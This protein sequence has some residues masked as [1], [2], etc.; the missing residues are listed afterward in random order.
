MAS[1]DNNGNITQTQHLSSQTFAQPTTFNGTNENAKSWWKR[2]ENWLILNNL[3]TLNDQDEIPDDYKQNMSKILSVLS[4]LFQG[5]AG[6]WFDSLDRQARCSCNHLKKTFLAKYQPEDLRWK[7]LSDIWSIRQGKRETVD[8][9]LF[10]M[11]NLAT[12]AA[13]NKNDV[14]YY[15]AVRQGPR[16]DIKRV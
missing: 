12:N 4:L 6:Q 11:H 1:N 16:E 13:M 15:F 8:H 3:L 2:L 10:R 7:S 5:T 9:Y 14:A